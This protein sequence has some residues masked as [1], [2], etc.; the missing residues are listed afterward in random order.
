MNIDNLLPKFDFTQELAERKQQLDR[1][2]TAR[3]K[4]LMDAPGGNLHIN[5]LIILSILM[6]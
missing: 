2:I 4:R 1:E 3:R 6:I 5:N